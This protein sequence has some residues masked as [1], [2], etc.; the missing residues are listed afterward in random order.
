MRG[1]LK[2]GLPVAEANLL[3]AGLF[4]RDLNY[5]SLM[6]G[7][8]QIDNSLDMYKNL[9]EGYSHLKNKY[10]DQLTPYAP[11]Y[12]IYRSDWYNNLVRHHAEQAR[13]I[14]DKYNKTFNP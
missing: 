3:T 9:Y 13:K 14:S 10:A 2:G 12:Q 5:H 11:D 4:S 7:L 6:H 1:G 8:L